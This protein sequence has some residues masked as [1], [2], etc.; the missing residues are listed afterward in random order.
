MLG[1]GNGS[2]GNMVFMRISMDNVLV[3]KG[4]STRLRTVSPKHQR[5]WVTF[6]LVIRTLFFSFGRTIKGVQMGSLT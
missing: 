3:F 4:L 2:F 6:G 5:C 1:Q